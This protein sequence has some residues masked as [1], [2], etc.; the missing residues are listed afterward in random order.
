[1]PWRSVVPMEEKIRFI[2][3]YLNGVFSFIELCER[4]GISRKTGYKWV[5]RY[6]EEGIKGLD[7]RPR[8]PI[9]HPLKTPEYIEK[10][11]LEIRRKHPLWGASKVLKILSGRCP[12]WKLPGRTTVFDI[13]KRNG[14]IEK[15]RRTR[16]RSHPGKP[17]TIAIGANHLWTSDFKGQFKTRNGVYCYPL[18]IADAYSRYLLECKGL[19]SPSLKDTKKVF[20]TIFKEYGLPERIRT[21]NGIPFASSS[22]G[23][24]SQLSI[25]WIRLGIYPELIEPAS[26]Q[27]NGRHERMHRTLKAETTR[28]PASTLKDQQ[29][30]FNTFR[31]EFNNERPHEALGQEIPAFHYSRSPRSMPS[32]L[33]QIEYP[34]HYEVR[35]VSKNSGIRWRHVRVP[36]SHILAGEYIGFEEI[37]DGIWEVYYG[38]I[39][40]GRFDERIMLIMDQRGRYFRRKV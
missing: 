27:Q 31:K 6:V 35:L 2:G 32:K 25:W 20:T 10:A 36:V 21:D 40:L 14:C 1:M 37:D 30:Q 7:E 34:G 16:R 15:K 29:K 23:R 4:Y 3:D 24:L 19:L 39:W 22:L 17:T 13:L 8:R 28:P 12:E 38:P 18:T 5:D 11:I 9:N 33:K 26:P